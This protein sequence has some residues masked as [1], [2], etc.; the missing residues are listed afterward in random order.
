MKRIKKRI[1][2]PKDKIALTKVN[3]DFFF[4]TLKYNIEFK[5]KIIIAI[6]RISDN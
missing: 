2:S 1:I 6:K 3:P 4:V 5:I